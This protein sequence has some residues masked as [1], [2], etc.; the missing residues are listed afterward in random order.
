M[1]AGPRIRN[2]A[3]AAKM[4]SA[5]E[6]AALIPSGSTVG[7]AASPALATPRRCLRRSPSAPWTNGSRATSFASACSRARAPDRSSTR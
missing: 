4:M 7:M 2:Q 3:L 5:A 1:A 6:A